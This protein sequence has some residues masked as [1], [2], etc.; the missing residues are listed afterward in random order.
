MTNDNLRG[1]DS[2]DWELETG[3]GA[4]RGILVSWTGVNG[5]DAV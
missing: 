5:T 1:E 2:A 3:F 4:E